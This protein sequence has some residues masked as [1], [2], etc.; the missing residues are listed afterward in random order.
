MWEWW[1]GA[2]GRR[3]G[4]EAIGRLVVASRGAGAR[5]DAKGVAEPVRSL[6]L[7]FSRRL[8][9]PPYGRLYSEF[10]ASMPLRGR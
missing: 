7:R 3:W 2:A 4:V 8:R 6:I 10:V 1:R 5:G 9:P